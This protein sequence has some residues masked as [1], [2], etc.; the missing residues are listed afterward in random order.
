LENNLSQTKTYDDTTTDAASKIRS[1]FAFH[2]IFLVI[3]ASF[4]K[5]KRFPDIDLLL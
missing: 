5:P 4:E 2:V 1:L 3:V